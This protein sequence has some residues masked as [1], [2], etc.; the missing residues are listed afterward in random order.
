MYRG[1]ARGSARSSAYKGSTRS[2][3]SGPRYIPDSL[4]TCLCQVYPYIATLFFTHPSFLTSSLLRKALER[5]LAEDCRHNQTTTVQTT[6]QRTPR[7]IQ[8]IDR[9]N[10]TRASISAR[11]QIESRPPRETPDDHCSNDS[12]R[13]P[14]ETD[15]N[16]LEPS[17]GPTPPLNRTRHWHGQAGR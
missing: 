4:Y 14:I 3:A 15:S 10:W 7:T 5:Q 13:T 6:S 11:R 8:S 16:Q 12:Q 1:S 17:I 9:S 2:S